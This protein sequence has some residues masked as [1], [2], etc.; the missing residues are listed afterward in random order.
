MAE[1]MVAYC[2]LVCTDCP[3]YIATRTR[4][5]DKAQAT[6]EQWARDYKVEVSIDD[7]WCDGCPE[8]GEKCAHCAECEIRACAR[9][10]AVESCAL[11]DD[12]AC[13]RL[14]GF[15]ELVPQARETLDRVRASR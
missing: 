12:Y 14:A 10:R 1:K 13:E 7:V 4:D 8:G 15:F 9:G 5:R 2:G 11:C 6:A 3:A